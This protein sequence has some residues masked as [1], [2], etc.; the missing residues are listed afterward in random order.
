MTTIGPAILLSEMRPDPS[1]EERFNTWYD[2]DHIPVRMAIEGFTGTQRYR[3]LDDDNYLVIY[4]MTSLDVLKTPEYNTVKNQPSEETRWML[5][6]V[7]N[8]T[9]YLGTEI[10]REGRIDET[11]ITAPMVFIAQFDVPEDMQPEFD[12]WM[13][14]DHVPTLLKGEHW[15]GTRRFAM[16]VGEPVPY[17]RIAIHYLAGPEALQSPERAEARASQWRQRLTAYDWFN[18]G[19]AKAFRRHGARF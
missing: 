7:S 12:R 4:D 10:A 3:A 9:R 2:T 1:W 8:F 13:A 5:G 17:N 16:T 19:H 18:K 14:E 6:N 11:S 15:L